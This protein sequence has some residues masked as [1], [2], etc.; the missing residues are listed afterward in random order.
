MSTLKEFTATKYSD[1]EGTAFIDMQE[2]FF[3]RLKQ[4]L[5]LS[6]GVVVGAGFEF[7]EIKG[8]CSLDKVT[9]YVLVADP[10]YGSTMDEVANHIPTTGA[11]VKR[12]K[13]SIPVNELGLFIKRFNCCGMYSKGVDVQDFDI[14]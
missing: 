5:E 3:E 1:F 12:F 2:H 10:E 8:E 6:E 13:K 4:Q 9:F 7:G 14:L 11:K